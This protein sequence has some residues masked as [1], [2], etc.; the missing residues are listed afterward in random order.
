MSFCGCCPSFWS[1]KTGK[2]NESHINKEIVEVHLPKRKILSE[3]SFTLNGK[4]YNI[5][6]SESLSVETSLNKFIRDHAHLPGTKFMC[7]EGGCGACIVSV[8]GIHPVTKEKTTWSV[9][10]CLFPVF[11]C[12]GLD[13]T[14]IEGLG[15][16][17]DG[18]H[19]LQTRL[20]HFNGTQCGYC[21]PAWVMS[22]HSLLEGSKGQLSMEQIEN[23]F[24]GN[25]CRCTGYRPIL[26][27]WKSVATDATAELKEKLKDIEDLDKICKTTGKPCSTS[28]C[29]AATKAKCGVI[30]ADDD[31]KE[32]HKVTTIQEIFDILSK[33]PNKKYMLVHGNTAH[34]VYRR[35][36]DIQVFIDVSNVDE[37]HT[38][39]M[40]KDAVVIGGNV[41]LTETMNILTKA[42]AT[43]PAFE[44]CKE[45]VKH[46]DL[47]AHVPVRNAGT[48]AGNLS[49]KHQ[50][51]EFPSDIFLL[52]ET[53]E[54]HLTIVG[55]DG[56]AINVLPSAFLNI[57]MDNKVITKI[58]LPPLPVESYIFRS[59]K[60]M[61]RAQNAHAYVNAGFLIQTNDKRDRA[62]K[63][64]IV[65]GG[66][67]PEFI[68]ATKLEKYLSGGKDL[69]N[70]ASL[71][72]A[73]SLLASEL[74]PD[75]VLP[76]PSPDF[77]KNLAIALFYKF[78]LSISPDDVVAPQFK[79]GAEILK[80][81][82]SSGTQT[83]D[84]HP[85]N[86]PLT[87]PIPKIEGVIQC[88]G[89]AQF[90]NDIP[91]QPHELW[92]ALVLA[93]KVGAKIVR[94]DATEA[95]KIKGVHFFFSAKDI[96]GVNS[97]MTK[98]VMMVFE[99]EEIFV[100][101]TVKYNGQPAGVILADTMELANFA[102]DHVKIVYGTRAKEPLYPTIK[103]VY[104][105]EAFE[106]LVDTD[107]K[108]AATEEGNLDGTVT[109]KDRFE[110]AGQYHFT[111][112]AQSC[113]TIPSDEGI[114]V[115]SATQ[116]MDLTQICIA[117]ALNVPMSTVNVF[118]KR[119]G[120]GYGSKIS[121]ATLVACIAALGT[122]L[123]NRT[124]R[125]VLTIE[126]NMEAIGK[127]HGVVSDYNVQV[128]SNGVIQ[129]LRNDYSEDYGSSSNEPVIFSTNEFF[130]NCYDKARMTYEGKAAITDAA[131]NTWCRAPGTT[132]GI[133]M[134][135]NIM[136]HIAHVVKRDPAKVRMDN[137]T[138]DS[139]IRKLMPEFLKDVAYYERRKEI[140]DFN[141]KN[142]WTKR[143]I[144]VV[145]MRYP[146]GFFGTFHALVSIYHGDGTVAI[147]H[148]GIE[149]GQGI[150]TKVA[151]VAAHTLGIDLKMI[152][153]KQ[154]NTLTGANDT[155][156]GGS[157]ASEAVSYAVKKACEELLERLKPTREQNKDKSW[158]ELIQIAYD[159]NVDLVCSYIF[160]N[161]D[162]QPYIIWGLS[163]AEIEIDLLTGNYMLRR[164]DILEDT[165]ESMSPN[166][167]V[168]QVEGAFIMGMGY[169]LQEV[170]VYDN[171]TGQLVS[172]RTWNYKV[173]TV[174][175]IPVDFRIKFLQN[176]KNPFG[177]LRSKATGEPATCMSIVVIFAVRHALNSA[178][179]DAGLGDGW[180]HLGAPTTCE[181]MFLLGGGT[182]T[183]NFM[184]N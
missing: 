121:R 78:I 141:T 60:I 63:A 76:D 80:R 87:K 124:V 86:Y 129:K 54:A 85:E 100:G 72:G 4:L 130:G 160:K 119:L 169:W 75:W 95:L 132:E 66:I 170:L 83:F 128:D 105:A 108:T 37:L 74:K 48:L 123:T 41:S 29:S 82:L 181:D 21:S 127:R 148:G 131:A 52:L 178:R 26:D 176:S 120:G 19:D 36:P 90:V 145:P 143:G 161:T 184:L 142:R 111:M 101:E 153:L 117:D 114:N 134:I 156:T 42:A 71:Q 150:N 158:K 173:P 77:R 27:A 68:H 135:E 31:G 112:E 79:S 3:V 110:M 9:N 8:S 43:I 136:E 39:N 102:A 33:N 45:M 58:T 55:Q 96:P 137:L 10:S 30:M 44:Y 139:E 40:G 104:K 180:Y 147:T 113:V 38:V 97:F 149:M 157:A 35:D 12:H 47:V 28:S 118:T 91:P 177:V 15:N 164:V 103:D 140:D 67:R 20:A 18:Y 122:H 166:V 115:Y 144:A 49:I 6:A 154:S 14:T 138:K 116:W 73:T 107:F 13:I 155:V 69:F 151:Q 5:T 179:K 24:G 93:R 7:L 146:M 70:N 183:E 59:Y 16:K 51:K 168:G 172:N 61:P 99:D 88:A 64:N 106:R 11:S 109:I 163:C 182:K 165:G 65:Y 25:I 133:A 94:I 159:A 22:M 2:E 23:S 17:K 84:T 126:R 171:S 50:H 98:K 32:W 175:D 53:I 62:M 162:V 1:E 46:I 152:N 174:K 92:G 89:E 81:P 125:L 34:G 167:D 57:S 56:K